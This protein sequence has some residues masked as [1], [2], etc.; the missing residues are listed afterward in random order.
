MYIDC[1]NTAAFIPRYILVRSYLMRLK[2]EIHQ[3]NWSTDENQ[4][5]KL[6]PTTYL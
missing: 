2:L 4:V 1:A 6:V 3:N 5:L